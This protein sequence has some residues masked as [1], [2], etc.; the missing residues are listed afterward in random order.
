MPR[1]LL[2]LGEKLNSNA[3]HM[4]IL[5]QAQRKGVI[6]F[7]LAKGKRFLDR[8]Q[9]LNREVP[10]SRAF[11]GEWAS[12]TNSWKPMTTRVHYHRTKE[13]M[14]FILAWTMC[15]RTY[16]L[17]WGIIEIDV[18]PT[19]LSGFGLGWEASYK[20]LDYGRKPY[21]QSWRFWGI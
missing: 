12:W 15:F 13:N 14:Q 9:L 19:D 4:V 10:I 2:N 17:D 5:A 7:G 3:W 21:R 16:R 11:V 20:A 18:L 8:S 6:S 1:I